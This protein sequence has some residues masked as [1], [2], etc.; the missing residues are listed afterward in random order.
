MRMAKRVFGYLKETMNRR[1]VYPRIGNNITANEDFANDSFSRRSYTG[2]V[3]T[4]GKSK[5]DMCYFF[6]DLSRIHSSQKHQK[7]LFSCSTQ[8]MIWKDVRKIL[9]SFIMTIKVLKN[10]LCMFQKSDSTYGRPY[11]NSLL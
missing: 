4:M 3:F 6:F 5:T 2:Y 11:K 7:K 9:L 8:S 1:L 10:F